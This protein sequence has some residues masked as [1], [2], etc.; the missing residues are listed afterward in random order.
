MKRSECIWERRRKEKESEKGDERAKGGGAGEEKN[1][2]FPCKQIGNHLENLEKREREKQR[3]KQRERGPMD[4]P[5]TGTRTIRRI[6]RMRTKISKI[7]KIDQK[8]MNEK[9]SNQ[10]TNLQ[11][12][13]V[14]FHILVDLE[15]ERERGRKGER[16][17]ELVRSGEKG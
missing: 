9:P 12:N 5:T 2:S 14:V 17:R 8:T 11:Q 16:K 6:M 13:K 10:P 3:Q 7:I 15:R 4:Q 1:L